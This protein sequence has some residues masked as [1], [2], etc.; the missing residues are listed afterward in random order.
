MVCIR[1]APGVLAHKFDQSELVDNFHDKA[2]QVILGQPLINRR[3]QQVRGVSVDGDEAAHL[4]W[5]GCPAAIVSAGI[6]VR[7]I[8]KPDKLLDSSKPTV[9]ALRSGPEVPCRRQEEFRRQVLSPEPLPSLALL[10]LT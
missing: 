9:Q 4:R 1:T 7:N 2:H 3:R 5:S 6:D 8:E 10:R